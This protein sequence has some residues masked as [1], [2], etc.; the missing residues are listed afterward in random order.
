[1]MDLV[2][3]GLRWSASLVYLYDIIV[4]PSSLLEHMDRLRQVLT[5]LL[6][7]NLKP[8]L[9]KCLFARPELQALGHVISAKGISLDPEKV[10]ALVDFPEPSSRKTP[11]GNVKLI[12]SFVGLCSYYRRFIKGFA[13]QAYPLT[14]LTR[15][16]TPFTWGK[17]EQA[18]F[19]NLKFALANSALLSFPDYSVPFEVH[20]D[21]CNFGLGAVLLQRIDGAER[22]LAYASRV[23]IAAEL[24]GL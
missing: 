16:G 7:A 22:P 2:L 15:E 13:D 6:S 17:E 11:S 24:G 20:P 12:R 10:A 21:A 8:K 4:Y 19:T 23:L 1:M 9:S 3:T 14:H 18:S 5:C